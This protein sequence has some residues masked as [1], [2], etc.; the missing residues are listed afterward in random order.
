MVV[1]LTKELK[2]YHFFIHINKFLSLHVWNDSPLHLNKKE[3]E[4]KLHF[5][6]PN[7]ILNY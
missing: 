5:K 2:R 1:G 6:Y 3:T 7:L 4:Q